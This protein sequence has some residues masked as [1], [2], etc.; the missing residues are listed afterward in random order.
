MFS[1]RLTQLL[2]D[3]VP[4]SCPRKLVAYV[5]EKTFHW[6]AVRRGITEVVDIDA[7]SPTRHGVRRGDRRRTAGSLL[8]LG[9]LLREVL[10]LLATSLLEYD[11]KH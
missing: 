8:L 1:G 10:Q 7:R 9:V 2:L 3:N 4:Y 5:V 6:P 11:V